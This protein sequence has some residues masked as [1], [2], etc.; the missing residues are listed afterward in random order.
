MGVKPLSFTRKAW[1]NGLSPKENRE[2]PPLQYDLA[3]RIKQEHPDLIIMLNG[4]IKTLGETIEFMHKFD[5][6]MI[7]REAY[8]N[9]YL[10]A[11]IEHTIWGT[12]TPSRRD[13]L[14]GMIPYIEQH[15]A[16]GGKI[17][18]IS[19]A[20]CWGWSMAFPAPKFTARKCKRRA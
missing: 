12:P 8:H 7:G 5:G 20:I 17:H 18:Q 15:V 10:L 1:L 2:I 6:V 16:S 9:P 19:R 13:V 14:A 3:E 11:Q 4:G